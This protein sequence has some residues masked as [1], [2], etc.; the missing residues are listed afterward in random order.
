MY[1]RVS[2]FF[3][4]AVIQSLLLF[5]DETW[6]VTLRMGRFL[7][8]FQDQVVQLLTGWIPWRRSDG[9]WEYTLAEVVIEEAGLNPMET[10]IRQR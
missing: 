6:L 2:V 3:L 1:G 5:G 8:G 9:R 4:K 10:Y 7:G